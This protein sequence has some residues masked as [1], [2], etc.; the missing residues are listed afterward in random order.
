MLGIKLHK[1]ERYKNFFT[2]IIF[3]LAI[4][5]NCEFLDLIGND[6]QDVSSRFTF[7]EIRLNEQT[8]ERERE[9]EKEK[10]RPRKKCE[11]LMIKIME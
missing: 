9:R 10:K 6:K 8:I 1:F 5:W 2:I 11:Y 4:P 7:L 3:L